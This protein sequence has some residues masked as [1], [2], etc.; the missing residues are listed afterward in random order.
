MT[1]PTIITKDGLTPQ[2]PSEL[3]NQLIFRAEAADPGLTTNLPASLIEDVASTQV[4]GLTQIDSAR[5][6]TVDSL[7]PYGANEFLLNELGQIYG[8][9]QGKETNTSVFVVFTGTVGFPVARGFTVSDGSHQYIV[10]DG[11]IVQSGGDTNPLFCLAVDTG[12]WAIPANTVT[13][14]VTSVPGG[15]SLSCTNPQD[16]T[17]GAGVQ[18]EGDYRSQVLQ[19][20]RA[21]AQGMTTFLKTLVGQVV[22]VQQRLI[23]ARQANGGWEIIVGGGDPYAVA[24]AIFQALFDINSLVGSVIGITG[25]TNAN[26]GVVTTDLNH[27]LH[28]GQIN[29]QIHGVVGMSGVNGGPYVATVIDEK[30]FSFGV[31]TTSSG[32]YVSGGV[33]TPNTRNITVSINDYPDTYNIPF[34]NP[35]QQTVTIGLLWN[36][37]STNI[38]SPTAVAQLGSQA[39]SDYVNSIPVGLPINLFELQ[40]VFQL[41][42]IDLIPTPLL[43][44]MVFTVSING[45]PTSVDAGTGLFEGDPESYF[46]MSPSDVTITQG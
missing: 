44:R 41:A 42:I 15:V 14:L 27:G 46:L 23:S 19:A 6:E 10:Q 33:V 30:T 17:P 29:V 8:V 24:Y 13:T 26:P 39:I 3:R 31:D 11:G 32:S 7:T 40:A 43:S 18:S 25:I 12:S 28:T 5:V 9:Q 16:G 36:T 20:G 22:G 1:L 34:V 4:A 35:P 38:V 45:V 37:T 2:S 21:A